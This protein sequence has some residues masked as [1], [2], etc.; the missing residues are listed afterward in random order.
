VTL[1][2]HSRPVHRLL[3]DHYIDRGSR[4]F[5]VHGYEGFSQVTGMIARSAQ[6]D[7]PYADWAL[8]QIEAAVDRVQALIGSQQKP[9]DETL[10]HLD[11][12]EVRL[13]GTDH[14]ALLQ[15]S[16]GNP[17]AYLVAWRLREMDRLIRTLLAFRTLALLERDQAWR[18]TL[19]ATKLMRA[20]LNL[21]QQL[22]RYTGITRRDLELDTLAAQRARAIYDALYGALPRAEPL[23]DAVLRGVRRGK[24]APPILK[25]RLGP[26]RTGYLD[27][28]GD[29]DAPE[30]D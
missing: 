4:R 21:P 20:L 1:A 8:L 29:G 26:S 3:K 28:R 12:V 6:Y 14:P 2:V 19:H 23:P 18:Q 7:D 27:E 15:E 17:Y 30:D 11:D 22:W 9:L 5:P 24:H 25:D 10:R 16:G 13:P